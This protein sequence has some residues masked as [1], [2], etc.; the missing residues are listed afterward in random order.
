MF[1]PTGEGW[2][3]QGQPVNRLDVTGRGLDEQVCSW[4]MVAFCPH[5]IMYL[6]ICNHMWNVVRPDLQQHT[7]GG[8]RILVVFVALLHPCVIV[9]T[10]HPLMP[11][12]R[13]SSRLA[14]CWRP[15]TL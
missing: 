4:F 10:L 2:P 12:M 3:T 7:Q 13:C 5:H 8:G 15:R 9:Y 11:L 14:I 6:L 1:G